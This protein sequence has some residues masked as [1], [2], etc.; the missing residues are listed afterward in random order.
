[1]PAEGCF[2]KVSHIIF[3]FDGTLVGKVAVPGEKLVRK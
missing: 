2:Q 3:D 1:M